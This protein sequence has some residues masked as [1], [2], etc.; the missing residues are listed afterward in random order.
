MRLAGI[1]AAV[2]LCIGGAVQFYS[3]ESAFQDQH[4]DQFLISSQAATYAPLVAGQLHGQ[5]GYITDAQPGSEA[6]ASLFLSAQYLMAPVLLVKGTNSGF[7]IGNF[8]KPA[9]FAAIGRSHGLRL[10]RDFGDGLVL[11]QRLP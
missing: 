7:V 3:S 5:V 2:L 1:V 11:Y 8:G 4:R 10:V 6:D 9:E